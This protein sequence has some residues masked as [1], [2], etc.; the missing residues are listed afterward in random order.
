M[1]S[2]NPVRQRAGAQVSNLVIA[3]A[4]NN[5]SM[6]FFQEVSILETH[7][8][9]WEG[10][11]WY[12][13]LGFELVENESLNKY[14]TV[15]AALANE[16]INSPAYTTSLQVDTEIIQKPENHIEPKKLPCLY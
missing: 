3:S 16:F 6:D 5:I 13:E 1:Q 8:D 2:G 15:P 12:P 7:F 4:D 14:I 9:L 10:R 11:S